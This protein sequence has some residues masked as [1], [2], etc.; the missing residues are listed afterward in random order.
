ML[1]FVCNSCFCTC[2]HNKYHVLKKT[3]NISKTKRQT[4]TQHGNLRIV[5]FIVSVQKFKFFSLVSHTCKQFSFSFVT[6]ISIANLQKLLPKRNLRRIS[7]LLLSLKINARIDYC[8]AHW[9][10]KILNTSI[11]DLLSEPCL[12]F[13]LQK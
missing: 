9:K 8:G 10:K 2:F 1:I 11:S 3:A 5:K 7:L 4:Q 13:L 12:M 6:H